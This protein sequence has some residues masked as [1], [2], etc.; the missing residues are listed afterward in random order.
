M[1]DML[2]FPNVNG[3]TPEEQVAQINDFLIQFKEA[4]EFILSNISVE[5]LSQD[6]VDKL[7]KLG[8]DIEQSVEDRDD[9]IQQVSNQAITVSDVINS[10]SFGEAVKSEVSSKVSNIKFTVNFDTGNLEYTS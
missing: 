4:L 8:A 1:Y 2:P 3:A 7:N 10:P 5:N 9:Q 6:L